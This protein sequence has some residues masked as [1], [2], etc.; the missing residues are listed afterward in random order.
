MAESRI[1]EPLF[2]KALDD[3]TKLIFYELDPSLSDSYMGKH[4]DRS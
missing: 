4:G 3:L 1:K 2:S